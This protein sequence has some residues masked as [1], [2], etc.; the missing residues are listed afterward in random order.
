MKGPFHKLRA[1][2]VTRPLVLALG[3]L[4]LACATVFGF[5]PPADRV[6][7]PHARHKKGDVECGA[8]HETIF[9]ATDLSTL[10]LP[11]EKKCFECHKEERDAKKCEFC[12]TQPTK[13]LPFA[14]RER[15]LI[16]NHKKHLEMDAI[17]EDCTKCHKVL[18]EPGNVGKVSWTPPMEACTAC[19]EHQEMFENGECDRC[20]LDLDRFPLRPVSTFSHKGDFLHEHEKIARSRPQAC[21]T[22][23]DVQ[24]CADCHAR[25]VMTKV[26]TKFPERFDR[27]MIHRGDWLGRHMIEVKADPVLCQRC[28]SMNFCADCH[29]RTG[30]TPGS[31]LPRNPHGPGINEVGSRDFHGEQARRDIV[32]CAA[33]H[34]QGAASN[35]VSCHRVGGVGGNPH[36]A[37]WLVRHKQ[38]E[39]NQN[40]MC[41]TCHR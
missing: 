15:H 3:V 30:V 11:K 41:L 7:P 13:P 38:E 4:A 10:D 32:S 28:H 22:C 36:P 37:S 20:H 9:D 35:C 23:H 27:L 21:A 16:F 2:L 17:G 29:T 19:H 25:T 14:A 39:I 8:C 1:G 40:A 6:T 12:H 26:E 24:F 18:P 5:G 34:D 33:C 31:D